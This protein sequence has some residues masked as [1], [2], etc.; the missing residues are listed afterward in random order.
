MN[1]KT[2]RFKKDMSQSELAALTGMHQSKI[3]LIEN[4][5]IVPKEDD[6][7]L[8]EAVLGAKINWDNK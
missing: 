6:K 7:E 5:L 3:S 4:A 2:A 1:L 8:L